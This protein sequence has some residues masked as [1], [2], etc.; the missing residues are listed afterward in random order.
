MYWCSYVFGVLRNPVV[1]AV[2]GGNGSWA[3]G[4]DERETWEDEYD[5][6]D[7]EEGELRPTDLLLDEE[8]TEEDEEEQ[9]VWGACWRP[10]RRG[11]R[12]AVTPTPSPSS[13][14]STYSSLST[15]STVKSFTSRVVMLGVA[16][17]L[18]FAVKDKLVCWWWFWHE[19][20]AQAEWRRQ[21]KPIR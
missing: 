11:R 7:E 20:E 12:S 9:R 8:E 10:L 15:D 2:L 16:R 13:S 19:V 6:D 21:Q 17:T 4:G 14:S 1:V 18:R 3:D 5:E